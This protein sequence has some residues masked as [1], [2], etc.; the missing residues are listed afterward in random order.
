MSGPVRVVGTGAAG[1]GRVLGGVEVVLEALALDAVLELVASAHALLANHHI[2]KLLDAPLARAPV[3]RSPL[4]ALSMA[5]GAVRVC[6]DDWQVGGSLV[7]H[8]Y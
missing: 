4:I 5:N 3:G 8:A 6:L 2:P 1:S 7:G